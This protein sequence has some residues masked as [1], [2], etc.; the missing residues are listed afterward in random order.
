M[1]AHRDITAKIKPFQQLQLKFHKVVQYAM[2]A[3]IVL[4]AQSLKFL[5]NQ[6]HTIQILKVRLQLLVYHAQQ[7]STAR[8]MHQL[9]M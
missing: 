1:I 4:P 7:A 2:Q 8:A 6:E 3:I 9:H 5:V